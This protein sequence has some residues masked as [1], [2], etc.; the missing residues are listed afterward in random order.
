MSRRHEA[1]GLRW[2]EGGHQEERQEQPQQ[3]WPWPPG[4]DVA[5]GNLVQH[6]YFRKVDS[7]DGKFMRKPD[8]TL[9]NGC[10]AD[11]D[12][13]TPLV[14]NQNPVQCWVMGTLH[15]YGGPATTLPG[16]IVDADSTAPPA[17]QDLGVKSNGVLAP[18]SGGVKKG[19][20]M[21]R[22]QKRNASRKAGWDKLRRKVAEQGG[23]S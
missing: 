9:V 10:V 16:D 21:T 6:F 8:L 7:C 1:E 23:K 14:A 11:Y 13:T 5:T 12:A 22:N 4:F 3:Q 17:T 18:C 20:T 15:Q 19:K 2:R